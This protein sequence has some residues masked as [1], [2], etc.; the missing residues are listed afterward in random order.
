MSETKQPAGGGEGLGA[1]EDEASV[2]AR[3]KAIADEYGLWAEVKEAYDSYRK[4]GDTP[5]QAALWAM[6]DY[7]P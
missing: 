1:M 5:E 6:Y 4:D 3:L 7:G 2:I